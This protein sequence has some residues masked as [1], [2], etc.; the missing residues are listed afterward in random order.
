MVMRLWIIA[1]SALFFVGYG[2]LST[3]ALF[4]SIIWNGVWGYIVDKKGIS[5]I[6]GV[7]GNIVLLC[8]FKYNGQIAM[9]VAVSFYTFQQIAFLVML[10][11]KEI[12]KFQVSEYL[13]IP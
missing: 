4:V 2:A 9:P 1:L 13:I 5:L 8:F 10:K 7:L 6:P 3:G 12:E 11:K